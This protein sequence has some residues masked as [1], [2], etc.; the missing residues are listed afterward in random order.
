MTHDTA[1]QS[2]KDL[3]CRLVEAD[4]GH[5]EI[6]ALLWSLWD[7]RPLVDDLFKRDPDDRIAF[8]TAPKYT[9]SLDAAVALVERVLPGWWFM[10]VSEGEHG[11][12]AQLG[13]GGHG[14]DSGWC[15]ARPSGALA[16]CLA[17][18]RALISQGEQ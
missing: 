18:V 17:C 2:L 16:L 1:K 9:F 12:N 11:W 14:I 15:G 10:I 6:D 4:G 3:E 7:D 8:D 5:G 13:N